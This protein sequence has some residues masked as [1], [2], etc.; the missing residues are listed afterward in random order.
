MCCNYC[1]HF[2][3]CKKSKKVK[4]KCCSDCA[5]F[6]FCPFVTKKQSDDDDDVILEHTETTEASE[7]ETDLDMFDDEELQ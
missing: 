7:G 1:Y 3:G 6:E 4:T 5:E 2:K